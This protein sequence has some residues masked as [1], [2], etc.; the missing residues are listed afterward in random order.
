MALS[1]KHKQFCHELLKHNFNQTAAYKATYTSATDATARSKACKLVE[2][3][4]IK[5]YL[6]ELQ[7]KEQDKALV[8]ADEIIDGLKMDILGAIEAKQWSAVIKARE[9]LG[10]YIAM[11]TDKVQHEGDINNTLSFQ[12]VAEKDE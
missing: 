1:D 5:A 3:D 7:Q 2:K 9:L 12:E 11:W 8:T 10:K 6:Y 4:N